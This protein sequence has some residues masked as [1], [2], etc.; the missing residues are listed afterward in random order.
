MVHGGFVEGVIAIPQQRGDVVKNG[1]VQRILKVDDT[2]LASV[3]QQITAMIVSMNA[4]RWLHVHSIHQKVERGRQACCV[5]LDMEQLLQ[6]P[7][8]EDPQF[9]VQAFHVVGL[10]ALVTNGGDTRQHVDGGGQ[11]RILIRRV[12]Q[13]FQVHT[14]QIRHQE[15]ATVGLGRLDHGYRH[16]VSAKQPGKFHECIIALQFRRAGHQNQTRGAAC[17]T[18]EAAVTGLH[19]QRCELF[20]HLAAALEV[21][22][23]PACGRRQL[24]IFFHP[25]IITTAAFHYYAPM[26]ISRLRG[27]ALAVCSF[28]WAGAV[29]AASSSERA[30]YICVPNPNGEGWDCGKDDGDRPILNW[31]AVPPRDPPPPTTPEPVP[32]DGIDP[33]TGLSSNPEDW[34]VAAAPKA[35]LPEYQASGDLAA[36]IYTYD[37]QASGFCPGAYVVREYPYSVSADNSE[38]PIVIEA[39]GLSGVMDASADLVGNVSVEQGNLKLV[40]PRAALDYDTRIVT[41]EEGVRVDQPGVVMQGGQASLNL[42]SSEASLA[43]AQ[44]VLLDAE[45]RGSA[46]S[47]EQSTTGDLTLSGTQFTRCEPGNN[48]WR[49]NT[50]QLVIEK[51]EVFGTARGVVL[52]M[53]SV[54]MFYTPYL[55]FPV[56]DERVSG[57]LFPAIGY[58]DE[59]GTDVS[60]PYYL[61]LAP[62]YDATIVPRYMSE[63]G[64]GGELEF[65]HM[66][67]WQ[68][69]VL[70]GGMLPEDDLYNGFID[71][72][73]FDEAGGEAVFGEFEP[74]D[75]WLGSIDH[76]G[77]FGRFR[78]I[79]DYTAVSDRDYF[80]DLGSDL[81][82]SSRRELQRRGEIRYQQG[83]LAMRLWAQ[84]FQ[85]LDEIQIDDYERLPELDLSY[86]RNLVGPL[87]ASVK[88]T[89]S[90]FDRDVDGLAGLNAITGERTHIEPRLTL[91]FSWPY[92]FLTFNGAY[93]YTQYDLEQPEGVAGLVIEDDTP[94]RRIGMGSVD[95]GL[96][97]ERDLNWFNQELIQTLEPRV[98]YLYQEFEDQSQLPRFDTTELTFSYSQLYREN[99]FSGLD[100]ISNANQAS[101]GVTTRF[102]SRATGKEYFRFS[103]G[104]IFYF[105]ER[106][107]T[108]AGGQT[109]ADRRGASAVAAEMSASLA[110]HWRVTGNAV[111][112]T[113]DR[114]VLESGGGIQYRSDNRHI[115]NLGYR[116]RLDED[117]EQTDFSVYWPIG[118]RWAIMGRWNYDLVSGRTVEGFGG[119]EYSDCC[120]QVRLMARRFLDSPTARNFE[121]IEADEGIF[122]QIVFKGL[123][124]FGNKVESVLERGIRGYRAPGRQDYFNN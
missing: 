51:D 68:S 70:A 117:I 49:L 107:V 14:A 25:R 26:K 89:W 36:A 17:G 67:S 2:Q 38:Y 62:N 48:G 103:L 87:R 16:V 34:Y 120:L 45:M 8:R 40:A 4:T 90:D 53:K 3:V 78:T 122:L 10:D 119:L 60:L 121:E 29:D 72:D 12:I 109:A 44:F 31:G 30:E 32:D 92:A 93:R 52:R 27:W 9:H 75:R 66:S 64:A 102:L 73:D 74:A 123:A 111:W 50:R 108:L 79:I 41:F 104:E 97:F 46:E 94:D 69:T 22:R 28:V 59:D 100:R 15:P 71:R 63:R 5:G 54:P 112:D 21:L 82:V 116:L 91:P 85:R 86:A 106:Q 11:R 23:A 55:K 58:S 47:L 18:V 95:G 84:R 20:E 124:G 33:L 42:N 19:T 35:I 6:E 113:Y 77:H 101:A 88:A 57:F 7:L 118:E 1:A 37:E 76:D 80:R 83:G 96:F 105:E 43:D 114:Q 39:D 24:G 81:G 65:R 98:Y 115:F 56:S 61:N 99:R 13:F 110:D